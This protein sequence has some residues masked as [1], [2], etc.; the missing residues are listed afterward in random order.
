VN[1]LKL[2]FTKLEEDHRI[3]INTKNSDV[4][5]PYLDVNNINISATPI[6]P[7]GPNGETQIKITYYAKD[8]KSGLG[9]VS[10]SLVDPQGIAHNNYHYHENFHSLFFKGTPNELKQ[11]EVSL[12][13]PEGAPPGKWGL[14]HI[15]LVDKASNQ[16]T[17]EFTE[18]VHFVVN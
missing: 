8:D 12:L 18:I 13:L 6:Y 7:Q 17:Y 14:T 2:D 3:L 5:S 15:K 11:Y 10:Y 9:T 1:V 4:E 16:K